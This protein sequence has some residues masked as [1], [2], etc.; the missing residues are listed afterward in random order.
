MNQWIF[1]SVLPLVNKDVEV[2]DNFEGVTKKVRC[3][4]K[5]CGIEFEN[6]P[7]NLL[8][9]KLHSSATL[10]KC[11]WSQYNK[12]SFFSETFQELIDQL[13]S[14][15]KRYSK[16]YDFITYYVDCDTPIELVK[17]TTGEKTFLLLKDFYSQ[18]LREK[19][20]KEKYHKN[21]IKR[22]NKKKYKRYKFYDSKNEITFEGTVKDLTS[23]ANRKGS[24]YYLDDIKK[25]Q[26]FKNRF[27]IVREPSR[28]KQFDDSL[29]YIRRERCK[30]HTYC[31][32][33]GYE[34][35]VCLFESQPYLTKNEFK[36]IVSDKNIN[37][38]ILSDFSNKS[39][40][41][42][43]C[44]K[45]C[46]YEFEK[47]PIELLKGIACMNCRSSKGEQLICSYLDRNHIAYTR[48][49]TFH[50]LNKIKPLRFD[51]YLINEDAIIEFDGIQHYKPTMFHSHS[52]DEAITKFDDLKIRDELKN[53]Y[54]QEHHIPILRIKYDEKDI[55]LALK[56]FIKSIKTKKVETT[57]SN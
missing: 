53:S 19:K 32:R 40:P 11:K 57:N 38:E 10:S 30:K 18:Y 2:L 8:K 3:K 35:D 47:L 20:K 56:N 44:C 27:K 14:L 42:K 4:C 9:G 26:W 51:F 52:W 41:I 25:S 43:C 50:G 29:T 34:C 15:Y 5:I 54:C 46:G 21:E 23:Y 7:S 49:K 24:Y 36:E 12:M 16:Q 1:N 31:L 33:R 37:F 55:D 22:K 6:T 39:T 17:R 45:K 13:K 48:E 28:P